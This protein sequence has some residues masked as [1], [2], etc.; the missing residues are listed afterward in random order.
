M[1]SDG[2]WAYVESEEL[3]SIT[4]KIGESKTLHK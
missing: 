1:S 3:L 4:D 2:F